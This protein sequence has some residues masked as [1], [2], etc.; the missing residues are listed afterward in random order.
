MNNLD[1]GLIFINHLLS[2]VLKN[3]SPVQVVTRRSNTGAMSRI[4]PEVQNGIYEIDNIKNL[5]AYSALV[6]EFKAIFD[7]KL[8]KY[9]NT[10]L[11]DRLE[12]LTISNEAISEPTKTGRY[13]AKLNKIKIDKEKLH[14][15]NNI[16]SEYKRSV[17][18]HELIHMATTYKKGIITMV[19]FDQEIASKYRKGTGLNEGYTELINQRYFST[20]TP[21]KNGTRISYPNEQW[22]AYGIEML[23]G[24]EK[25]EE[26]FFN[27][28]LD[29]LLTEMSKYMPM[30]AANHILGIADS[31][32]Q[33]SKNS[34]EIAAIG[35]TI[36]ANNNL[37][38]QIELYHNGKI[39]KEEYE[40]QLLKIEMYTQ[41]YTFNK[42]P[43]GYEMQ[44]LFMKNPIYLSDEAYRILQN[45]FK[46]R[47]NYSLPYETNTI[48][49]PSQPSIIKEARQI[50]RAEQ[51]D[52][53]NM[54][55]IANFK[56]VDVKSNQY[57]TLPPKNLSEASSKEELLSQMMQEIETTTEKTTSSTSILS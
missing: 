6:L 2:K 20:T 47:P 11:Y 53:I 5:G 10:A 44:I 15:S 24:K 9:N 31:T 56:I 36:L 33:N 27:G 4:S 45:N 37:E 34:S 32:M 28:D 13:D 18:S 14:K 8:S 48:A 19:G 50:S 17:L 43:K 39:T 12:T 35:K 22:I 16:F 29:G 55:Q 1:Y 3:I 46:Q 40:F 38:K 57:K 42:T 26:L 21:V 30:K 41:G 51:V 49:S 23:V 25:M 52:K 7:K 54:N